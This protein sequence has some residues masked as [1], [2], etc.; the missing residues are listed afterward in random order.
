MF[1]D[2]ALAGWSPTW[3]TPTSLVRSIR[4][5]QRTL[6]LTAG[7][8]AGLCLV[9][10]GTTLMSLMLAEVRQ[11]IP[12][13]GLR[14]SLGARPRDIAALFVAESLVITGAAAL[15]GVVVAAAVLDGLSGRVGVPVDRG[16][17]TFVIPGI[18]SMLLG[19]IFSWWPARVASRLSPALALRNG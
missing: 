4:A 13:I 3:V 7:G 15:A 5:L 19:V 1:Q 2:P 9:L 8:I 18:A 17:F 14:R 6:A 11:R 10:G 12:E 16:V